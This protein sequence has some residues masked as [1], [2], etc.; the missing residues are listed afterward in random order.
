MVKYPAPL[1]PHVHF[2]WM[3]YDAPF[4]EWGFEDAEAVGAQAIIEEANTDPYITDSDIA[5]KRLEYGKKFNRGIRHNINVALTKEPEQMR[6]AFSAAKKKKNGIIGVKGFLAGTTRAAEIGLLTHDLQNEAFKAAVAVG[7]EGVYKTHCEDEDMYMGEFDPL[8]PMS[9]SIRQNEGA[10]LAS[11][12]RQVRLAHDNKFK[13]IL[14]LPHI[15]S[16]VS[17]E[18]LISEKSRGHDYGIVIETTAHHE[19]LNAEDDYPIHGNWVKMNPPLRLRNSQRRL[20]EYVIEGDTDIGGDD[21]APHTRSKKLS[22]SLASGVY[23]VGFLPKRVDLW[24]ELGMSKDN[25]KKLLVGTGNE[26]Y[27]DGKLDEDRIV[28]V[29]YNPGIWA[30]YGPNVWSRVDGSLAA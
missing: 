27:Y 5:A 28:D 6:A 19:W 11:V 15:S 9:H 23:A 29:E 10:E 7:Y 12:M 25:V 14:Y 4:I 17:V 16:P 22:D 24:M 18:Y 26:I 1:L 20:L 2:R 21:H 30:K 8:N 3:E 13:G